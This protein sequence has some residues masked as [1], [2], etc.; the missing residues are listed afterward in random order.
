M[1]VDRKA[2]WSVAK[3]W[4]AAILL[5]AG[6]VVAGGSVRA[7]SFQP[8]EIVTKSG[9]QVFSVEMATTEEEKQTGLMYRKELADGK[10]MLFDF[11]PEQE[12][13]M[14]MK[15][16]YVPLD[17]I[18]IRADGRIL[19]IAENTEPLSTKIISSKG[20][21]RAVLE[22]VAGTAQKYGIRPGDRVG[23]PLFGG[24]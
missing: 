7:A 3:G 10:G 5:I 8:L 1:N 17:M 6:V 21:A 9:V 20:P 14:W 22:V 11:N 12:V 16:T 24:K 4:L 15:N 2:V 18:F 19:R 23:H 13:S